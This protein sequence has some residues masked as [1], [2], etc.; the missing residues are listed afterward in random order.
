MSSLRIVLRMLPFLCA[1]GAAGFALGR[2]DA[3]AP[4]PRDAEVFPR[5]NW[6]DTTK[7]ARWYPTTHLLDLELGSVGTVGGI[8]PLEDQVG[9]SWQPL[10]P[11]CPS[12]RLYD[13]TAVILPDGRVFLPDT[14]S[15][16]S[17]N[18]SPPSH[19]TAR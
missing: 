6:V 10:E 7:Y 2:V 4:E 17:T 3:R 5:F 14:G 18:S 1:A 16:Q 11:A 12:A 15:G 9:Q 13:T 8:W 19:L